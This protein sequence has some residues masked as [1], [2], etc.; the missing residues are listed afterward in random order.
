[1]CVGVASMTVASP[2]VYDR[3]PYSSSRFQLVP[4]RGSPTQTIPSTGRGRGRGQMFGCVSL[5]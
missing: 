1:M 3:R 2:S 4:H 5:G